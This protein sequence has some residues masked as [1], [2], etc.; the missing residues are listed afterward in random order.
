MNNHLI[1]A[2]SND[3]VGRITLNKPARHNALDEQLIAA[4]TRAI[5]AFN[6][7]RQVRSIV[8]QAK[9]KSFC[10]G[11]DL[12][13]M[14]RTAH[15]SREDNLRDAQTLAALM[16]TL[17]QSPKPTIARLQ[18]AAFGGGVGL[19]ACC[20]I[21]IASE[22]ALFC[23]S[24][25]SLG[26]VPA[27]ISPYLVA[28]IGARATQKLTL[29]AERFDT[30]D[31]LRLGLLH[32][33]VDDEVQLDAAVQACCENLHKGA[34]QAQ[35]AAKH[36]IS[37]LHHSVLDESLID[38]SAQLIAGIRVSDEGRE[39]IDAFLQKRPANWS[40]VKPNV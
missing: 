10:A 18:G 27:V 3:G 37:A 17:K 24:E 9:G 38:E 22:N 31:A 40:L 30:R 35:Q 21:A 4:L 20:D 19:V 16:R 6:R 36:F 13:W 26:L 15:Y 25:V 7:N 33:I 23:L 14:K 2:I 5:E 8:L 32:Q 28:A 34:P 39:G 1:T 29:T 11:A 12:E